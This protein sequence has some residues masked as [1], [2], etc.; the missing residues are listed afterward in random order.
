M[1]S[2]KKSCCF[3]RNCIFRMENIKTLEMLIS[4]CFRG[5]ICQMDH[6]EPYTEPYTGDMSYKLPMHLQL[7]CSFP[8][9]FHNTERNYFFFHFYKNVLKIGVFLENRVEQWTQSLG[10]IVTWL[11]FNTTTTNLRLC[12]EFPTW[13]T[14]NTETFSFG[15]IIFSKDRFVLTYF[16][17]SCS[18][19]SGGFGAHSCLD[20]DLIFLFGFYLPNS[21]SHVFSHLQSLWFQDG[22]DNKC[23]RRVMWLWDCLLETEHLVFIYTEKTWDGGNRIGLFLVVVVQV[24][25]CFC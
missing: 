5:G 23:V 21:M 25:D 19:F 10:E 17:L 11:V 6:M 14:E 13:N 3:Q 16:A 1:L 22:G 4:C 24:S 20:S 8:R 7:R 15:E 2:S 9:T 12:S 18:H